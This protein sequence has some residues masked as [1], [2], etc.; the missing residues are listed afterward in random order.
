VCVILQIPLPFSPSLSTSA[1]VQ[2]QMQQP[3]MQQPQMQQPQMQQ[4]Q[5]Q[6]PQMQAGVANGGMV[7]GP[8]PGYGMQVRKV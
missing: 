1:V 7:A 2:P 3:Q 4:P 8:G 6:Q 5:M